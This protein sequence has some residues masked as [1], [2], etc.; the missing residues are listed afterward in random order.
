M[1]LYYKTEGFVFKQED[2]MDADRLFSVFTKDFGRLEIVGKAIRKIDSKLRAG[3]EL[4]SVCNIEF[5]EGKNRKTLTDAFLQKKFRALATSPEKLATA[6]AISETLDHFIKG[7]EKDH[8]L[9]ALLN[10]TFEILERQPKHFLC[11]QYFLWNAFS[12]LGYRPQLS[13]CATCNGML[14]EDALYFSHKEGGILC[15]NCY[16]LKKD[17][18]KVESGAVKII[19]LILQKNWDV[20]QKLKVTP[21]L[22]KS[23]EGISEYYYQYLKPNT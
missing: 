11:Q 21:D 19:R 23:L 15:E 12:A 9:F 7:Q 3:I 17:G 13:L 10:E 22:Q 2:R 20:L 18:I 6:H 16:F 8:E 5:V 4:F 14:Q 1:A